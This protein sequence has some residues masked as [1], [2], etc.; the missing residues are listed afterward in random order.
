MINQGS[1]IEGYL[2]MV[3]NVPETYENLVLI[4]EA[5][6]FPLDFGDVKIVA[7][8]KLL[9]LLLGLHGCKSIHACPYCE[10]ILIMI[11]PFL[12]SLTYKPKRNF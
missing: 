10:V 11:N 9:H 3:D 6:Q 2:S 8:L 7:D 4:F 5:L 12:S 1:P